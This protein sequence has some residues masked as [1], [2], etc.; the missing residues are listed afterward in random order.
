MKSQTSKTWKKKL[1]LLAE[2]LI[3]NLIG[4][5]FKSNL[6][7]GVS[8]CFLLWNWLMD[9]ETQS[10]ERQRHKS[11]LT[12]LILAGMA[13]AISFSQP[14]PPVDCQTPVTL[15]SPQSSLSERFQGTSR[16]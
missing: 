16:H 2:F 3:P 12:F 15:Q 11:W 8:L 13:L 4:W 14:S 5:L 1:W 9:E 10:D 6:E 7:P